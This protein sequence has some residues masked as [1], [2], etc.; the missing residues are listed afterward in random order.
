MATAPRMA[1]HDAAE[2][3]AGAGEAPL[4]LSL[5]GMH[6]NVGEGIGVGDDDARPNVELQLTESTTTAW[7]HRSRRLAGQLA[8]LGS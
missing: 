2:H 6:T 7:S 1:F 8:A 3:G 4:K 5:L